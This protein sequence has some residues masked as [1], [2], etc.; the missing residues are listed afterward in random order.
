MND[1]AQEL[2]WNH[3]DPDYLPPEIDTS[4]PSIARVYDAFLGGKDNFAADRA[5]AAE[6][7]RHFPDRG[8]GAR[9]NR[10]MLFRGV[11]FMAEQG[12]DQFLDIGSGLPT[13]DNTHSVA[14]RVNPGAKVVYVDNDP[15]VLAHARALLQTNDDTR[16]ITADMRRP[17]TILRHP[18]IEGFLDLSRPI[19]LLMVAVVHHLGDAEDPH[20]LVDRYKAALAPGSYLQLTH[21]CSCAPE[22]RALEGVLLKMLG[23][24][25]A[26]DMPEILGFFDG[27]ELVEPGVVHLPEWRPGQPVRTPLGLGGICIAGGVG[28]KP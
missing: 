13:M 25:R 24:G 11:R 7:M 9:Q 2:R 28:R 3:Q 27:L 14:Q 15:I 16:V 10:A 22:V 26:R 12:I 5:V 4:K 21:F 20:G 17:D 6:G 18:Q 23:T 19:G 8:E 1:G